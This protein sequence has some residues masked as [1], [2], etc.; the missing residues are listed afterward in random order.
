MNANGIMAKIPT[1]RGIWYT[2]AKI[3]WYSWGLANSEK[4]KG[5]NKESKKAKQNDQVPHC[6]G[7]GTSPNR[8][9][10]AGKEYEGI[11]V[12]PTKYGGRKNKIKCK[13][14]P[15]PIEMRGANINDFYPD[16]IVLFTAGEETNWNDTSRK[17]KYA[18]NIRLKE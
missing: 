2:F 5:E 1:A 7:I 14:L 3:Y 12:E 9:F 17:Y 6:V 4:E 18:Y 15:Y 13:E 10:V 11:V 16:E 8:I